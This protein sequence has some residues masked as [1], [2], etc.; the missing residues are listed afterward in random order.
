MSAFQ[1]VCCAVLAIAAYCAGIVFV[2]MVAYIV[3]SLNQASEREEKILKERLN[4]KE[5]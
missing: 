5:Y 2:G 1:I 3:R 4:E